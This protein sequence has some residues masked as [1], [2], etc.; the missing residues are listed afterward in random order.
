MIQVFWK[1]VI[2]Y[3]MED[4]AEEPFDRR[5]SNEEVTRI[6]RDFG[7]GACKCLVVYG[8]EKRG[9]RQMTGKESGF[10]RANRL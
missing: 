7:D 5:N 6:R 4:I 1:K 9:C 2:D 8:E 10:S 3:K